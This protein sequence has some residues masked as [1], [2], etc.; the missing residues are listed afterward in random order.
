METGYVMT[1][2]AVSD[3]KD[4]TVRIIGGTVTIHF[5]NQTMPL[6]CAALIRS[7]GCIASSDG[8]EKLIARAEGRS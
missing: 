5:E 1:Y 6:M 3:G 2:Q 4:L 7:Q 8:V